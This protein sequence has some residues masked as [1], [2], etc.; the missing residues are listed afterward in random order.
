MSMVRIGNWE[1]ASQ[2]MNNLTTDL[3]KARLR[4][5]RQ[6][7]LKAESLAKG[8]MSA[9]DLGWTALKAKTVAEKIRK[10]QS[11]LILI[12][13]SSYFQAITSWTTQ[14]AALVGVRRGVRGKDGQILDVVAATHE[15][16]A[17]SK[18]IPARPLWKIVLKETMKWHYDNNTPQLH[19]MNHV[20]GKTPL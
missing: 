14:N 7:S 13:T 19:Y 15:Y 4:S 5:L 20:T 3:H 6:W 18:N 8:H 17:P 12:A 1:R 11:D 16:G 9:Q 10:G 2:I